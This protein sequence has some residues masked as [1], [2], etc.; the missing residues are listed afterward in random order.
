M[1][2]SQR[3]VVGFV[4]LLKTMGRCFC[5]LMNLSFLPMICNSP[6]LATHVHIKHTFLFLPFSATL[7][8]S[9]DMAWKLG[10]APLPAQVVGKMLILK[11]TSISGFI[12]DF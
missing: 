4:G 6:P 11:T 3:A 9:M 5:P 12:V 1:S 7:L 10:T 8:P 2:P